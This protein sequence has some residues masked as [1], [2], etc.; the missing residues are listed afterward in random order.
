MLKNKITKSKIKT[1]AKAQRAVS[2]A[3]KEAG[4]KNIKEVKAILQAAREEACGF[5][6]AAPEWPLSACEEAGTLS[7]PEENEYAYIREE[8]ENLLEDV[9]VDPSYIQKRQTYLLKKHKADKARVIKNFCDTYTCPKE[10]FDACAKG[11]IDPAC[12]H[13]SFNRDWDSDTQT[14]IITIKVKND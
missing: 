5:A 3:V 12:N 8:I 6:E 10:A 14:E 1:K 2:R 13:I 9:G 7:I 11:L 4:F